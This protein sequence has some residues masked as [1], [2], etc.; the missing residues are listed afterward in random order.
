MSEVLTFS[1]QRCVEEIQIQSSEQ[2]KKTLEQS[3]D[4]SFNGVE[5]FLIAQNKI[6][7]PV[8]FSLFQSFI[9]DELEYRNV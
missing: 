4:H 3:L 5:Y 9:L 6:A 7:F 2:L 1:E 8:R